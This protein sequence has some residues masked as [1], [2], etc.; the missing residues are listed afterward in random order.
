MARMEGVPLK[1]AGFLTR[2]IYR[3]A[4]RMVG[5]IPEPM[6]IQAHQPRIFDAVVGFEFFLDRARRVP[7]SIKTLAG[8]QAAM[9]IGCPF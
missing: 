2:L 8:I 9:S 1:R 6:M 5:K 4:A 7:K 3:F